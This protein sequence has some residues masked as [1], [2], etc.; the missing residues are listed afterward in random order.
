MS[1]FMSM[2]RRLFSV[3]MPAILSQ[4][5]LLMMETVSMIFI[6]RLNNNFA[7]AGVGLGIIYVNCT[8]Q[9]TLTGLNN[10]ISVLVAVAYGKKDM[11]ECQRIL[12]RG[13]ILCLLCYI[14]L[15][16][17]EMMCFPALVAVGVE[18]EVAN[19]AQS[20]SLFLYFAM[21][22]HMQFDCYRQ[23]LNATN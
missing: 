16:F 5:V 15:F 10:A 23:Y 14:P 3:V 21:G 4:I 17:V 7:T 8:T 6:G 18:P 20:F 13:R 12:H 19:Y 2:N 1:L 11:A 22:F 9:S